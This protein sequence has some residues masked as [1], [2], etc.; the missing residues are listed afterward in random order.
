MTSEDIS[1][2]FGDH[3]LRCTRQRVAIYDAL[4]STCCHPTADELYQTVAPTL[5]G[6]SLA[7]VY[8]TL[9]AF[10]CAGIARK[11]PGTGDNG[12]ARYDATCEPHLHI[13][14]Q[15]TG[16]VADL[17]ADLS[18]QILER[19]PED[20]LARIES[21]LGFKINDVQIELVGSYAKQTDAVG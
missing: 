19:I 17:P 20:V 15:C 5:D 9:E 16:A 6:V 3:R 10:C 21:D 4:A 7:T 2:L 18:K 1:Q 13:R 8:N 14:C 12:S 11:L